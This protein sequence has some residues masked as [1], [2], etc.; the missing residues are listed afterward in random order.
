MC[1]VRVGVCFF[2]GGEALRLVSAAQCVSVLRTDSNGHRI[3]MQQWAVKEMSAS[4]VLHLPFCFFL[5]F[6]ASLF[7]S[8]EIFNYSLN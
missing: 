1:G 2:F 3:E 5:V 7:L 6:F 8:S 4:F